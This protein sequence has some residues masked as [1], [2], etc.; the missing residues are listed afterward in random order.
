MNYVNRRKY[1]NKCIVIKD[2]MFDIVSEINL[3]YKNE[4][5]DEV[6]LFFKV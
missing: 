6:I 2:V 3:A 5:L 1:K 4:C